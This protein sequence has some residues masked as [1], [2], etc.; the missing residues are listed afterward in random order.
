M[1]LLH[2]F[3]IFL[4]V[5]QVSFGE[6]LQVKFSTQVDKALL[7]TRDQVRFSMKVEAD[8]PVK[9]QFPDVSSQLDSMRIVDFGEKENSETG[10][11]AKEKYFVLQADLA[12][13]Y[14]L[15]ALTLTYEDAQGIKYDLKSSEIFIEVESALKKEEK[16]GTAVSDIRELKD[17]I[18][19]KN[20]RLYYLL[21]IFLGISLVVMGFIGWQKYRKRRPVVIASV[22]PHLLA[23]EQLDQ[24]LKQLPTDLASMKFFAYQLSEIF[25]WY[26]EQIYHF[27]FTDLTTEEIR[28][29]YQEKLT[30]GDEFKENFFRLLGR[31]DVV[32]FTDTPISKDE[33]QQLVTVV[34]N[35]IG[36]TAPA[37]AS[38]DGKNSEQEGEDFL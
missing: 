25:R 16:E 10:G 12:G 11:W 26:V 4:S 7:T 9:F 22:A 8:A 32:K 24:M 27:H 37:G 30:C 23:R 34:L 38:L 13:S 1:I 28:A 5:F 15:P 36:A 33:C 6:E 3:F 19:E 35:F 17:L 20:Y 31:L 2:G 18:R 14:I 21:A 29:C